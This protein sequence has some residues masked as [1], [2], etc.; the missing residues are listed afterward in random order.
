METAGNK[1]FDEKTEKKGLEHLQREPVPLKTG[2]IRICTAKGETDHSNSR[3]QELIR[4]MPENLKSAGLTAEW[5]N[6]LL[7]MERGELNGEQFMDDIVTMLEEILNGCR[8]IPE[9]E[10]NRFQ[11]AKELIGKCPVCGSDI[12]R[13]KG[14]FTARIASVILLFGRITDF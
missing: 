7:L 14:I 1:E 11:T 9:E 12:L 2:G 6:R 5:E 13:G 10:R 8:K 4:V 3:G